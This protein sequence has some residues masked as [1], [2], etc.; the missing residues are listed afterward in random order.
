MCPCTKLLL[1]NSVNAAGPGGEREEHL[2]KIVKGGGLLAFT[3]WT[4]KLHK[5]EEIRPLSVSFLFRT[6]GI[7]QPIRLG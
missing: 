4:K 2:A 3:Q 5:V 6:S 1:V 7:S